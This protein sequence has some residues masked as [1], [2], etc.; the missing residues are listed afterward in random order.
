MTALWPWSGAEQHDMGR[1]PR[2]TCTQQG[3]WAGHWSS[4]ICQAGTDLGLRA[5]R[6]GAKQ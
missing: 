6:S 5:Q 1:G 4:T 2:V 3:S